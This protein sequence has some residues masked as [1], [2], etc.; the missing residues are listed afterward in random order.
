MKLAELDTAIRLADG[1]SAR[2]EG[3]NIWDTT[4]TAVPHIHGCTYK[5]THTGVH[6]CICGTIWRFDS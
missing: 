6:R 2:L 1:C 3:W 4:G 5:L